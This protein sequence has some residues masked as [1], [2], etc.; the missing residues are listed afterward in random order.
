[1]CLGLKR[2]HVPGKGDIQ[3]VSTFP[4]EKRIRE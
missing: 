3:G 1:M 2:L 4:E